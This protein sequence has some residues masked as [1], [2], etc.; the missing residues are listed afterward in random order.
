MGLCVTSGRSEVSPS[1]SRQEADPQLQRDV[2]ASGFSALSRA[3]PRR[4]T[5][6]ARDGPFAMLLASAHCKGAGES[7]DGAVCCVRP[8]HL[9][10]PGL[11]APF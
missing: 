7:S 6:G 1:P 4:C 5:R 11:R 3:G 8:E 10:E 9:A 2:Q